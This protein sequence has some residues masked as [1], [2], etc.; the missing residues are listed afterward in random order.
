[1][2]PLRIIHALLILPFF[3]VIVQCTSVPNR[4][5]WEDGEG[6]RSTYFL[7]YP[8]P[9]I[10][11]PG[12]K[13]LLKKVE[14]IRREVLQFFPAHP[15]DHDTIRIVLYKNQESYN[16][17]RITPLESLADFER[18]RN[19]LNL[20][21]NA[22]EP[23][24]R[25]EITHAML[26]QWKP[27]A[28]F[29]LH[30]GLAIFLQFNR[31]K[32]LLLCGRDTSTTA[33][34]PPVLSRFVRDISN[35]SDIRLGERF[36][37]TSSTEKTALQSV[38]SAYFIYYLWNNNRLQWLLD[39]YLNHEGVYPEFYLTGGNIEEWHRVRLQFRLWMMREIEPGKGI[40]FPGC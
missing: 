28:P 1:M 37:Y 33:F 40:Q 16:Q 12:T 24:W 5:P 11:D 6:A 26:H 18:I 29:W 35:H 19:T 14:A 27:Y 4:A 3:V 36:D 31:F 10:P 13:N 7:V 30:E 38:L 25:H 9:G 2:S 20:A 21:V 15:P 34:M 32:K 39:H 22:P 17:Y 23:Y 8:E